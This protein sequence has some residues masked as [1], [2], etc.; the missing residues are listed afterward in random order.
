M[1]SCELIENYSSDKIKI[2]NKPWGN[3]KWIA[4]GTERQRYALKEIF[5]KSGNRTSLQVH[6]HK[7]ETNYVIKGKGILLYHESPFDFERFYSRNYNVK[8][9]EL[10]I[11]ELKEIKLVPGVVSHVYA[12]CVHRVVS[13]EDLTFVEASTIEL[14]DVIRLHD[15][16]GR[17][18]GLIQSEH[19]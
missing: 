18:H 1:N 3:E 5:F 19:E 7:N 9:L 17:T 11:S 4:Q 15:D 14:N 6:Q 10:L 2:V 8:D 12:G 13:L 16:T